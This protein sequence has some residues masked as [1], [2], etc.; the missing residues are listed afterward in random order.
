MYFLMTESKSIINNPY[1]TRID[2]LAKKVSRGTICGRNGEVLAET[3]SDEDGKEI[4]YYPFGSLFVHTVGY[5]THGKSGVEYSMN[6]E[7][8][9]SKTGL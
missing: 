5:N 3:I 6:Y 7:L 8:L 9:T 1:N 4:R 2:L